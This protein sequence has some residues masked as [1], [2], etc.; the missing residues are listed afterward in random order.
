MPSNLWK[1][2]PE[3]TFREGIGMRFIVEYSDQAEMIVK[4]RAIAS[5]LGYELTKAAPERISVGQL[6]R[7]VGR[8]VSTVSRALRRPSCPD[9]QARQGRRRIVWIIASPALLSFL[10][11]S[12]PGQ[13]TDL[14]AL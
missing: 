3:G 8:P 4:L 10:R 5:R 6:A 1:L 12:T 11:N 14:K 7:L 2:H 9:F 13:R